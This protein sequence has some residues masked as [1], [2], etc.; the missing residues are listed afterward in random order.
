MAKIKD[1]TAF[2]WQWIK[3]RWRG[4]WTHLRRYGNILAA[5]AA[6]ALVW[7]ISRQNDIA[8]DRNAIDIFSRALEQLGNKDSIIVRQGGVAIMKRLAENARKKGN[9]E[10][11]MMLIAVLASFVRSQAPLVKES[12]VKDRRE[13][14]DME[15]AIK[16]LASIAKG[17]EEREEVDLS[18]ADLRNLRLLGTLNLSY[19]NFTFADL[20]GASLLGT[21]LSGASLWHANLSG[22][23]LWRVDLGGAR[24]RESDLSRARLLGTDLSGAD[25]KEANLSGAD[26]FQADLSGAIL[27]Q[28]DLSG[29][30]LVQADLRG[31]SL[32]QADL[33]GA[34]LWRVDLGGARLRESDLSRANLLETDLS[35]ANLSGAN[36]RGAR[37]WRADLSK[38]NLSRANLRGI[39]NLTQDQLNDIRYYKDFPPRNLPKGLNVPDGESPI[40]K[41]EDD[42]YDEEDL[43]WLEKHKRKAG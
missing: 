23:S 8:E 36:L 42:D 5:V 40:I 13:R 20:S 38:A 31:V 2:F 7:Q 18:R 1:G 14:V 19:F 25:L 4:F 10:E 16:S 27:F 43:K 6:L 30:S 33:S 26:L 11:K 3:K 9:Q 15:D 32:V 21:D 41:P 29:A 17:K 28:A 39:K 35:K 24:L 37:L 22:A 34:R 12:D